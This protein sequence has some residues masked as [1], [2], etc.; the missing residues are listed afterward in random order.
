MPLSVVVITILAPIVFSAVIFVFAQIPDIAKYIVGGLPWIAV[1][2]VWFQFWNKVKGE[3]LSV[4]EEYYI[5]EL[6]Y[7]Y[8]SKQQYDLEGYDHRSANRDPVTRQTEVQI[9][10]RSS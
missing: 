4:S 2:V 6:P 9:E 10:E 7:K 5:Q 8:M 1:V 3:P